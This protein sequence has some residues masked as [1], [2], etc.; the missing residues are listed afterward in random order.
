MDRRGPSGT[1][2]PPEPPAALLLGT[3][4]EMVVAYRDLR[5]VGLDGTPGTELRQRPIFLNGRA[6]GGWTRRIGAREVVVAVQLHEPPNA[7][8]QAALQAQAD[9]FGAFV[10]LPARLEVVPS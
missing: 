3:Y 8:Q 1:A 7:A 9:R 6:A 2:A 10:G 4:D 5:T